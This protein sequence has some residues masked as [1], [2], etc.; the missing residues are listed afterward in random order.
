MS[1]TIDL[2]AERAKREAPDADCLRKD[3][4]G[5]DLLLFALEYNM[6]GA[7]WALEVWAYSWED[8][9]NRVAAMRESLVISG[10]I[11]AI[12]PA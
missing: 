4:Y 6:A 3:D 9:E 7:T 1:V 12:I 8:A 11:Q 10:Q 2:S 5:R